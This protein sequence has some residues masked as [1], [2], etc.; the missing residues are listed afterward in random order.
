MPIFPRSPAF[1]REP[2]LVV[3]V[4]QEELEVGK[5]TVDTGVVH[6]RTVTQTHDEIVDMPLQRE[7]VVIERV[8]IGRPVDALVEVRYEGDVTI[9]PVHEEVLVV[10]RRLV[11]KEELHI[12]RRVSTLQSTQTV[13]VR[14]QDVDV[15]QLTS[16]QQA[17]Q[18]QSGTTLRNNPPL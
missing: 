3:P 11:L 14:R 6:V 12:R 18:R 1:D 10:E 15:E 13:P 4:V 9:V 2:E 8:A 5:Q 16:A 17:A 7:D